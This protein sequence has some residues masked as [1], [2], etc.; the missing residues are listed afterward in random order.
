MCNVWCVIL[1]KQH[2]LFTEIHEVKAAVPRI[3]LVGEPTKWCLSV[4]IP[5]TTPQIRLFAP[6]RFSNIL[7]MPTPSSWRHFCILKFSFRSS[8][9]CSHFSNKKGRL[10]HEPSSIP[11]IGVDTGGPVLASDHFVSFFEP[12]KTG[13]HWGPNLLTTLASST[14]QSL[15]RSTTWPLKQRE[16]IK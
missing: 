9:Q 7:L 15:L 11:S 12:C 8:I 3:H 13:L 4:W 14:D 2:L 1:R 5:E 16:R 6:F 10:W